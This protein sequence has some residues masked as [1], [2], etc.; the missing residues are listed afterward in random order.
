M[1]YAALGS[2]IHKIAFKPLVKIN[3]RIIMK[4]LKNQVKSIVFI[5]VL[6]SG[7][8]LMAQTSSEKKP[9]TFDQFGRWRSISS[10]AISDD[11]QWISFGYGIRDKND[12][13]YIKS[14]KLEK[15]Y[16]IP[17]GN[18]AKFS[19]DSQW[20]AY[21]INKLQKEIKKLKKAK[22][23]IP[24][25][26]E[27][28]NLSSGEKSEVANLSTFKF[29]KGSNFL[30]IKKAKSDPKAKHKGTDLLLR[31]LKTGSD[32][33]IGS[34]S[35]FSFNKSGSML[36]YIIDTPDTTGNGIHLMNLE[37]FVRN[38]I[39]SGKYLYS[40]L[41]WD[42]EGKVLAVLKGE[43]IKKK[44][45]LRNR[46]VAFT[47]LG[48]LQVTKHMLDPEKLEGFPEDMVISEKGTLV[49]STDESKIFFGLKEQEAAAEKKGPNADPVANVDVWHWKDERIQS[50]QMK[51]AKRDQNFTYRSVYD[52]KTK[53]FYR[54]ADEKMKN[55][56]FTRNGKW[57]IGVD[58]KPYISDW[59]PRLGD[60]YRINNSTNKKV[61]I[62]KAH[63]RS[64]GLTPDSKYFMYWKEGHVWAYDLEKGI[65]KNI[66]ENVEVSFVNQEFDRF[67]EK[68][69]YGISGYSKD[70]KSV[71]LNAQFDLWS[72]PFKG[73]KATN[74]TKGEGDKNEIQFRYIKLDSKEKFI[75]LSKPLI[76]SAFGKWTKKAGFYSLNKGKLS[77]LIF[78]DKKFGRL[79]KAKKADKFLF[80]IESFVDFPDYFVS[81]NKFASPQ[82]VTDA[83][84]W[85]R[86]YKWGKQ[87][88]FEFTNSKGVRLQGTLGIP[89]GYKEGQKLPMIVDYYEKNSNRVNTYP[90]VKYDDRPSFAGLVSEGYL[91]MRPDIHFNFR[92]THS[93]MLECVEA[94]VKK[95]IEMGYADPKKVALHGH[96]FSGQGSAL[97]STKSEMFAAIFYGAGA[98]DMISDFNQIWKTSGTNQ[99]RYDIY[100]QGRFTTNPYDDLDLYMQESAVFH[101][102]SMN[103]PL[104]ILHGTADGSVDWLQG[105]EFYN[106]LRFNGKNVIL[107]SYPG[108]GHHL[109]KLENQIDFQERQMQF[110]DHYLK[111]KKA[112]DWMIKG[113]PFL[114]KKK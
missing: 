20:V 5:V 109:R 12:T 21:A 80:T 100:N 1:D 101:A 30:A 71:I 36:A 112:A 17:Q 87:I 50:V 31:N 102:R 58:S 75:D 76:L 45:E 69:P 64:L 46:L 66:T 27:L 65:H 74:L 28:L 33:L 2:I 78:D 54:L 99:H 8:S 70:G 14:L 49:W 3:R 59:K 25:K 23:P 91:V 55:V 37:T 9:L 43:K 106:A 89:D 85:Q 42:E 73:G 44:K 4:H 93:D 60:Y 96:S 84:P 41:S 48:Q 105:I 38:P 29:A 104:L 57:S 6:M 82:K 98:T 88:L 79:L 81:D 107:L 67:G 34:V 63:G 94:G 53:K 10:A 19:D 72:V 16:K 90:G 32:E 103:T 62:L 111:G 61:E 108:E 114:K 18:G 113:V 11:G 110:I 97:I 24:K 22:K 13:L 56:S 68:P 47:D 35:E 83:N 7:I 95:V 92:T 26:F 15:H 77:S 40:R 39:E 86:E 52:L 51:Q